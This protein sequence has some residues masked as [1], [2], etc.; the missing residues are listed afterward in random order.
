[1]V[2]PEVKTMS[3]ICRPWFYSWIG[4]VEVGELGIVRTLVLMVI[5]IP[6]LVVRVLGVGGTC[7]R[8]EGAG[9][10]AEMGEVHDASRRVGLGSVED[11]KIEGVGARSCEETGETRGKDLDELLQGE[12]E[13]KAKEHDDDALRERFTSLDIGA[14]TLFGTSS[15]NPSAIPIPRSVPTPHTL[16]DHIT[17]RYCPPR[18]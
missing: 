2:D 8:S 18:R 13:A 14:L 1:V 9:R 4:R 5:E 10:C 11:G 3:T 16:Q 7:V 12:A 17:S 6:N 15:S